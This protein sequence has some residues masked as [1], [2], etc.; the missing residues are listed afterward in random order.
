M[1]KVG[2]TPPGVEVRW[3]NL[4][5]EALGHKAAASTAAK[6]LDPTADDTAAAAKPSCV[7][8]PHSQRRVILD[9]GSGVLPPGRMCL[10]LGPPG[11]GRTTLLR[12][13]SG[14]LVPKSAYRSNAKDAT[15]N[16]L[17]GRLFRGLGPDLAQNAVGVSSGD[18]GSGEDGGGRSSLPVAEYNGLRVRGCVRYNGMPTNGSEFQVARAA[19]YVGQTENNLPELTVGETLEFAAKCQGAEAAKRLID[20]LREREAAAGIQPDDADLDHLLGMTHGPNTSAVV[21]QLVARMLGID[22]VLDTLV[23]N[24]MIKGI[25]GGQKRRVTLGE[26]AVGLAHVNM[27]DEITNGLDAAYALSIVKSLRNMV[28]YTNAT[29]VAT[30]LQPSPE[31]VA[32]FHDVML[33]AGGRITFF[34]PVHAF[35]PFFASLGLAPMRRQTMAD[36]AQEVLAS[37]ADQSRYRVAPDAIGPPANANANGGAG[38]G[39]TPVAW[40]SRRKWLSPRRV[41]QAFDASEPGRALAE[42]LAAPPHSDPLQ[43]LVL[44]TTKFGASRTTMWAAVLKREVLLTVRNPQ[45][46]IAGVVQVLL[47]A[48]LLSTGFVRLSRNSNNDANLFMSVVFLSLMTIFMGGFNNGPVYCSRLPVFYKQR[49][50]HFL[51]PTAYALNATLLRLPEVFVQTITFGVMVYFSVGFTPDAGRFFLFMLNLLVSGFNSATLFHFIGAVTRSEVTTQGLGAVLLMVNTLVSGFPIARTSI[52]GWWIWIYWLSPTSWTLRSMLITELTS[53]AWPAAEGS[54]A[55]GGISVGEDALLARGFHTEWKWVWAGIGFVAGIS[56]LQLAGQIAALTWLGPLRRSHGA[57]GEEH[58]DEEDALS[59]N[60]QQLSTDNGHNGQLSKRHQPHQVINVQPPVGKPAAAAIVT[61]MKSPS[62][63]ASSGAAGGAPSEPGG[64]GSGMAFTPVTFAFK[65]VCYHVPHPSDQGKQLQLLNNVSGVFRPGVLTSLM[66]ASGAGKTTLMDVLAGRKTGGKASGLQLVN[67]APK[68][69]GAF[70]RI[71]GYV[72]QV[73]VHN[74]YTTVEEALLFSARLR[75]SSDVLPR[76]EVRSF[77]RRMMGVV[78]L[79]PLAGAVIGAGGPGSGLSTEA[80]KRLTI[81]VELVANPSI[82]FMDEPTTGLDARAAALVMRAVRNTVATGRTVVCTIHQPNREIMDGFDELLLLKP[83]GRTIFF[84]PLGPR[85][86][87]LI[88]YLSGVPGTAEYESHLNP[89]DWMLEVTSPAAEAALGIDFADVWDAS[90]PARA[91]NQLIDEHTAPA[92]AGAAAAA[93]NGA[94]HGPSV[95]APAPAAAFDVESGQKQAAPEAATDEDAAPDGEGGGSYAQPSPVQ[96]WVLLQRAL[97]AQWRNTQYNGM[98][99]AVTFILAWALGSLYWG[100]GNNRQVPSVR[101][102][103]SSSVVAVMDIMGVLFSAL[104]YA[105]LVNM[106]VVMPVVSAERNIFYREKASGMYRPAVFAAA[107]GLAEMPFLVVQSILYV[108]IIYTTV[109]FEFDSAKAMWFWLY[110]FLGFVF[111]TYLGMGAI[112]FAPNIP[113]ATAT[114]SLF[115]LTWNMFCGFVIARKDIHPWYLWAYYF[116]PPTY[117]IYGCAVSQMGDLV[118]ETIDT[119]DDETMSVAQYIRD[120]FSYDYSYRGWLVLILVGFVVFARAMSYIGLTRFNYQK[121]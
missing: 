35:L 47:T 60:S 48:F 63:A 18:G 103:L 54:D 22:H 81:A 74:P 78:E 36:F 17:A 49:D 109:H 69:R 118:T 65:D 4:V 11:A 68:R 16:G 114:A 58:D 6:R 88:G 46:F 86:A 56:L 40:G 115:I 119:G 30:L 53:P 29:V 105:P 102:C 32:C 82:V 31:V 59:R 43:E 26:M 116:N 70:A 89:A 72:E 94:G 75:V 50:N 107:Q 8:K 41:R 64:S 108:I 117:M 14:Q 95:A 24:E 67:G 45:F 19:A 12:A 97:V 83:G 33:M 7:P 113:A 99:F 39:P 101:T 13:L 10:L 77:V 73:D 66:G 61:D 1:Q 34:G 106:M 25:S 37:P 91:A 9:A 52:P 21:V 62:A 76:A 90:E 71:M 57:A 80:R 27:L 5:V 110:V 85:Q 3:D 28:E 120:T 44:P 87:S 98:R 112:N 79:E 20:L 96:L 121:R 84:G 92:T 51:T 15:A 42:R 111:F 2:L 93:A 104:L 38:G 100:R 23:G 55:G